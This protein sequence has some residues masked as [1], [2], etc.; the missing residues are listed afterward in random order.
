[1]RANASDIAISRP[2]SLSACADNTTGTA[3]HL[4][5]SSPL[6]GYPLGQQAPDGLAQ[7]FLAG[8]DADLVD[9]TAL[10]PEAGRQT[11]ALPAGSA[12][13]AEILDL[14]APGPNRTM[15]GHTAIATPTAVGVAGLGPDNR[16]ADSLQ[17]ALGERV[18]SHC[19]P[20]R[21]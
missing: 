2:G 7:G 13:A 12:V 4:T 10:Q 20:G 11:R 14:Q 17:Y 21:S 1:M 9:L 15:M 19:G 18:S 6:A 16:M 8:T 5:R 3:G